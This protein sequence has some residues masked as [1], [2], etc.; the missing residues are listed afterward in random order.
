MISGEQG[1]RKLDTSLFLQAADCLG[2]SPQR[3]L[4]VG[5]QRRQDMQGA[6][7]SGMRTALLRRGQGHGISRA[8]GDADVILSSLLDLVDVLGLSRS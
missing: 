2:V 7:E 3:I 8:G 1:R 4:F 5:D 6:H